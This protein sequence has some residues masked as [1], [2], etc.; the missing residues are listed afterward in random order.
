[1]KSPE[2]KKLT[3]VGKSHNFRNKDEVVRSDQNYES[4]IC[5]CEK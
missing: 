3:I 4:Y 2:K 5:N 1:M